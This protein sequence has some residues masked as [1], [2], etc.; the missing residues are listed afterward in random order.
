MAILNP[1]TLLKYKNCWPDYVISII[2]ALKHQ[3]ANVSVEEV[4]RLLSFNKLPPI[5]SRDYWNIGGQV[6]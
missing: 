1:L 5:S 3:A 4:W 2:E 6:H